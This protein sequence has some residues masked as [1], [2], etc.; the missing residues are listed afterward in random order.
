[1]KPP[2]AKYKLTVEIRANTH[3]EIVDEIMYLLNG[4]YLMDSDYYKRDQFHVFGGRIT[5]RLEHTNPEMTPERFDKDLDAWSQGRAKERMS[6][7]QD[8]LG[9]DRK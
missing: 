1:M 2:V 4:G 7:P 5:S 6:D 9:D 3:I 8:K